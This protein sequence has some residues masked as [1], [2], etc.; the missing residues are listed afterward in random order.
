MGWPDPPEKKIQYE[1]GRPLGVIILHRGMTSYG[2]MAGESWYRWFVVQFDRR[3]PEI[4]ED[5][6]VDIQEATGM[7]ERRVVHEAGDPFADEPHI[8]LDD[9]KYHALVTQMGGMDI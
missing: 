9:D 4:T 1:F 5:D 3:V 2:K 8:S 7:Y 6:F